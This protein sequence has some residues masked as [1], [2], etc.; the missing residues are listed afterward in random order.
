MKRQT[1]ITQRIWLFMLENGGR[2]TVAELAEQMGGVA[3]AYMDRIV[4]S[5]HDCGSVTKYRSGQRKNGTAFGVSPRNRIPQGLSLA[6]VMRAA[7][8]RR[9]IDAAAPAANDARRKAA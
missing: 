5:M 8:V 4:W 2:W 6:D 1:G 9:A 3:C 7:G